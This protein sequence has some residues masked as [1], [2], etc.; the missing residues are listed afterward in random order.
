MGDYRVTLIVTDGGVGEELL[1]AI[2]DQADAAGWRPADS[3]EIPAGIRLGYT[4][5]GLRADVS[6]RTETE[7]VHASIRVED[8]GS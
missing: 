1:T 3:E 8:P 5:D 4:R 2:E 7:T 6:V